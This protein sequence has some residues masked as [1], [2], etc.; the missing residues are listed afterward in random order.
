MKRLYHKGSKGVIYTWEVWTEGAD[1]VTRYGQ[2]DGEQ[3]TARKAAKPKNV[4]K[5]NETTA[6]AQ[7]VLEARAMWKKKL[8]HKYK[9]SIED[10]EKEVFLPMLAIDFEKRRGKKKD[11]HTYPCDIQPKLDGVRCLVLWDGEEIKLLSRKGKEYTLP[12]ITTYL[13][14]R[15][16]H[17]LVLD[18][19]LYIHGETFQ[20]ITSWVKKLRPESARIELHVYDCIDLNDRECSWP[21]RWEE[22]LSAFFTNIPVRDVPIKLVPTVECQGEDEVYEMQGE[23]LK[24]GYEGAVVRMY[25]NSKYRFGYR[26]KRLLKVKTFT[27]AEFEVV[28]FT[29]GVGK[30]KDCV[31]WVCKAENGKTFQVVPKGTM[32]QRKAWLDGANRRIGEWLKV[33]FFERTDDGMPRFPVGIGFRMKEDM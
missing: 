20:T 19:E 29:C 13:R 9:E 15:L 17:S 1:I 23:Y 4:G 10:T 32:E 31:I 11:G 16:P 24:D 14:T 5:K 12:H 26:S 22:K 33:K 30:M 28:D 6:E 8:D 27:D 21:E 25:D 3:Q 7:A 2:L 18:G